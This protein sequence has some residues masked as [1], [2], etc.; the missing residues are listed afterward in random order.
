[1][2]HKIFTATRAR[3]LICA[4][5]LAAILAGCG[6]SGTAASTSAGTSGSSGSST[7]TIAASTGGPFPG[8]LNP[9]APVSGLSDATSFVYEPLLQF[10][11]LKPGDITPWLA[12]KYTWSNGGRTLT[13]G[14]RTGVKWSDGTPFSSADVAFT[15][16]YIKANP[17]IN[18]QG[19]QT[20]SASAPTPTTVKLTFATPQY[21]NLFYIGSQYI[22]PEHIWKSIKNP[23]SAPNLHPV[24][25]GPMTVQSFNPQA[26]ILVK[27]PDYWQ[28]GE[29][30]VDR[31]VFPST[32]NNTGPALALSQGQAQWGGIFDPAVKTYAAKPGNHYWFPPMSDAVLLLNLT[33]APM[34]SLAFR[35]A[36]N[37]TINRQAVENAAD[38]GLVKTVTNPT[39]LTPY[40]SSFLAPQYANATVSTNLTQAKAILTRAGFKYSGGKLMSP[41]GQPVSLILDNPGPLSDLLAAG[42]TVANELG[43]LGINVTQVSNSVAT[44]QSDQAT[45]NYDIAVRPSV[46]GPSPYYMYNYWLNSGL[47]APVGTAASGDFER[48][49]STQADALLSQYAATND[50]AQQKQIMYKLESI[51]VNQLPVI[52]LLYQAFWGE[53]DSAAFSGWPTPS[54]PYALA[55]VYDLPGNEM[56][57]LHL[58]PA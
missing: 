38:L 23:A 57:L 45:G 6:S 7:L 8:N 55:S 1:M 18:T 26:L 4:F 29:P 10:D 52:P 16:N 54:N 49:K 13:F 56:V 36:I 17:A 15:F 34:N 43:A 42:Q 22:L 44:W 27:N 50:P 37:L 47:S 31:V 19:L 53:Y 14:I 3:A 35:Q 21:A 20:V 32:D 33:K 11:K 46:A 9:V 30:K 24:G 39:M 41:S 28:P 58:K 48:F 12:T 40:Q 5:V 2:A 25:T 51:V